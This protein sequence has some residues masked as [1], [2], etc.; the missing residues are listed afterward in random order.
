MFIHGFLHGNSSWVRPSM[1]RNSFLYFDS[2]KTF[3]IQTYAPSPHSS[4]YHT[5]VNTAYNH[6]LK[7]FLYPSSDLLIC[8]SFPFFPFLP[9]GLFII[10]LLGF[11]LHSSRR[12]ARIAKIIF[13]FWQYLRS[14]CVV[15]PKAPAVSRFEYLLSAKDWIITRAGASNSFLILCFQ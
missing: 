4:N 13:S 7:L 14:V 5:Q 12:F 9:H 2:G 15:I 3:Q 11:G 10:P 6:Q 1:R 8:W